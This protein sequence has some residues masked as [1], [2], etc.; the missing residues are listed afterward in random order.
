MLEQHWGSSVSLMLTF[1]SRLYHLLLDMGGGQSFYTLEYWVASHSG[2]QLYDSTSY[3]IQG[4]L[5]KSL[6]Y[7][8]WASVNIQLDSFSGQ[9]KVKLALLWGYNVILG[10]DFL[11]CFIT[12]I[13]LDCIHLQDQSRPCHTFVPFKLPCQTLLPCLGDLTS[14]DLPLL[15]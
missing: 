2:L 14:F 1:Q 13:A 9:I 3:Q 6:E 15:S 7:S 8:Q 10:L 5:E 11:N 12:L 4:V